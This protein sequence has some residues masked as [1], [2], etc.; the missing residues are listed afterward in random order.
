[1]DTFKSIFQLSVWAGVA[2]CMH[3]WAISG[4][5]HSSGV[6]LTLAL[7]WPAIFVTGQTDLKESVR[8]L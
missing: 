1:M 3:L 2:H 8:E 7:S 6:C 4:V 5:S